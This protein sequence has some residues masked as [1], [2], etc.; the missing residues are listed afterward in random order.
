[1]SGKMG[2]FQL[3][4]RKEGVGDMSK[5]FNIPKQRVLEAWKIVRSNK[6]AGGIDKES[7]EDFEKNLKDN[8]YKIWNRMSSGCYFPPPVRAVD[9][10]KT[11]GT[12]R[13]GIPTVGDRVAQTVVKLTLEPELEPHFLGDSYGYRPGRSAHQAVLVTR[14]RCWQYD[15]LLEFD[16]KGMFDSIRHDLIMQALRHHTREKWILLYCERWLKAPMMDPQGEIIERTA[17][18]PQGGVI[19]P[20]LMNLFMHYG[21]DLWMARSFPSNLWVRYADDGCIHAKT[22]QEAEII[23][24]RLRQ[25]L[26]EIGLEMHSEK[27]Q[28]VYC[29]DSNRRGEHKPDRF[30]FLGFEFRMRPASSRNGKIFLSFQPAV[31]KT[32]LKAMRHYIKYKLHI[33]YRVDLSI[34]QIASWINPIVRGWLNY[35]GA[36]YKSA[37]IPLCRFLND[38]LAMWAARKYKKLNRGRRNAYGFLKKIYAKEPGLFVHWNWERP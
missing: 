21:F 4:N 23:R 14:K 34:V 37:L 31:A 13:L 35:Y 17:G 36:S 15:W 24:D 6:G 1:M 28:I 2:P 12:R 11:H 25:R 7:L 20:L 27:T 29:R 8:L 10:P 16:I 22:K 26:Q 33:R 38:T 5:S 18:T 3:I 19:S 9:I 30:D 32:K